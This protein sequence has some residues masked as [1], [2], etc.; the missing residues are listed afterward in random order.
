MQQG[1]HVKVMP[2]EAH[3]DP[4]HPACHNGYVVSVGPRFIQ[5]AVEG[6]FLAEMCDPESLIE[7][8]GI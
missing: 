6:Q 5:V 1:V 8:E 4:H 2:K 7:I 3:G